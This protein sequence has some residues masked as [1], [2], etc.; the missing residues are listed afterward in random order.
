MDINYLDLNTLCYHDN[1]QVPG[2]G[3]NSVDNRVLGILGAHQEHVLCR[4][5]T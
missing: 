2:C 3:E 1:V 4:D 5:T